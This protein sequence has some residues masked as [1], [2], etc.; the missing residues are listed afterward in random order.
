MHAAISNR[1]AQHGMHAAALLSAPSPSLPLPQPHSPIPSGTTRSVEAAGTVA[2]PPSTL[3]LS[4]FPPVHTILHPHTY[5]V[6]QRDLLQQ[7]PLCR[8]HRLPATH[9]QARRPV[10]RDDLASLSRHTLTSY[11]ASLTTALPVSGGNTG[12]DG[13]VG[14]HTLMV[15]GASLSSDAHMALGGPWLGISLGIPSGIPRA[16]VGFPMQ[17]KAPLPHP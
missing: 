17:V 15:C 11:R 3:P 12:S 2:L 16:G 5:Q 13:A 6:A 7:S 10:R 1:V 8:C 4:T 14:R 9:Q